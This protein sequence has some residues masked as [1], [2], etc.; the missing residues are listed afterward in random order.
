M[1]IAIC[2]AHWVGKTTI[3]KLIQEEFWLIA[4]KDIVVDAHKLGFIINEDTPIETQIRLTGKQLEQEKI[5][6]SFVADKCI[7]DYH[8]YAKGLH[9]DHNLVEI[10]RK[11]ALKTYNYDHIFYIKPEFPI[12]DDWLRSTNEEFQNSIDSCYQNFLKENKIDYT[13]LTWSI[14]ER[15]NQVKE[16]ISSKKTWH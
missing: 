4:L 2:W 12:V 11:V 3:A 15:F 1:K 16:K 13:N 5:H 8:I 10:T 9:M 14:S 7:F 6:T